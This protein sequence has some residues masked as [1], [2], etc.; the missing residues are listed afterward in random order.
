M[1]RQFPYRGSCSSESEKSSPRSKNRGKEKNKGHV[2]RT[3]GKGG[4]ERDSRVHI[5]LD[6]KKRTYSTDSEE[7]EQVSRQD[8]ETKM[9]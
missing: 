9:G 7:T 1:A 4:E 3:V 8:R 5:H 6:Q 2:T